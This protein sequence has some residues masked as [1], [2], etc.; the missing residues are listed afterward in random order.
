MEGAIHKKSIPLYILRLHR[1][2]PL[3][4]KGGLK[5]IFQISFIIPKNL[6]IVESCQIG[7]SLDEN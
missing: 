5:D 2:R 4:S 7:M 3:R 6:V 1:I